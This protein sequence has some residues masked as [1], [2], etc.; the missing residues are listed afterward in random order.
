MSIF[1]VDDEEIITRSLALILRREGFV[2]TPFTNPLDALKRIQTAAQEFTHPDPD[3]LISDVMMPELSG[4][5]LAIE[6]RRWLP[7]CKILLFSGAADQLLHQAGEDGLDFRL[8]QKP[9][10]PS[11][12]LLEIQALRENSPHPC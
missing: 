7:D 6:T 1:V 9:L 11:N 12:L 2:V 5:D 10:H 3:I 4:I 8:L